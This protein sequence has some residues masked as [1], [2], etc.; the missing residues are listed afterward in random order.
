M[1]APNADRT[2]AAWRRA[3]ASP[4]W[5]AG[6][7]V[8]AGVVRVAYLSELHATPWWDQLVVDP[9]YYDAWA[10]RIA[11]GDWLGDRAFYMDPLYP[12][13]LGA[14]YRFAGRDLWLARL[15]NVACSVGACA[16]TAALGR[17]VGGPAVG[18][19]AALGLALYEPDVFFVGEIDK[20]SLSMLLVAAALVL[21]F[22]RTLAARAATGFVLGLAALTRA[23]VLVFAL[24]GPVLLLLDRDERGRRIG[25]LPRAVVAA[26]A[27]VAGVAAAI[28]PVT[29]R[30]HHVAGDW[31]LTT[32][33]LGQNFYTGNNPENPYGAYGVVSFVRANP[34]F[35][36]EDFHAA[37][38]ARA[39]RPL[40]AAATSWF[41]MRA[42]L[43][44]IVAAPAFALR[45]FARK[46]ALFWNDFEISDSQDQYLLERDARVLRLP[47]VGFGEV[48][49][50]AVLG[51]LAA[52]RTTRAVRLL[53]ASVL[54]YGA[55]LVAFFI[56]ARYRIQVV[57]ALVPLAALGL[58]DLVARVRAREPRRVAIAVAV[59]AVTA[60]SSFHT[61]GLFSK[62][63]PTVVE[64]RM[65]H[66]ADAY[67]TAGDPDRAI[68]ALSEAVPGCLH[69]CPWALAD[70]FAIYQRT[71]RFED[72]IRYFER[73]VRDHPEQRDAPQYLADLRARVGAANG[74]R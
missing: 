60:W 24:L 46:A 10:R 63:H 19:L 68:A 16:C 3:A 66:L 32:T 28:A 41:W 52:A 65:R 5:L 34:H 70:L 42:G 26:A 72:G 43:H 44:H 22:R 55:T 11:A 57:P 1:V 64:M 38:E 47:L 35:E 33:Q 67:M 48:A 30:N 25:P 27:F 51:A 40:G 62:D 50:F 49:A 56:F 21:A 14:L 17:R 59:L 7:L 69:G 54:V 23:N 8:L 29:W 20:T 45:A 61:I 71:A 13:V 12:Y 74:T 39:G 37:A 58:L 18:N 4:W 73:F 6:V 9:E 2:V 53:A 36:E 15:L 31:V